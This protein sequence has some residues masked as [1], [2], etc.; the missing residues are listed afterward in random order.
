[1][2]LKTL[3]LTAILVLLAVPIV[4]AQQLQRFSV[5]FEVDAVAPNAEK[6]IRIDSLLKVLPAGAEL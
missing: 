6:R 1:M 4:D 5:H 3:Y 2:T